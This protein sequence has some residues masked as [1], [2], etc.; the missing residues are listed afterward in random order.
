MIN[1]RLKIRKKAMGP[2]VMLARQT[3]LNCAPFHNLSAG[4]DG[5]DI[6]DVLRSVERLVTCVVLNDGH[7]DVS[8]IAGLSGCAQIHAGIWV[9]GRNLPDLQCN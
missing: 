6:I 7:V 3:L 2:D 9:A 8:H 4:C 1:D 5:G